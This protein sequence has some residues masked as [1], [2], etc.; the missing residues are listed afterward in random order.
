LR[1]GR[2]QSN[3]D[4]GDRWQHRYEKFDRQMNVTA[5]KGDQHS[6]DGGLDPAEAEPQCQ[7]YHFHNHQA[8]QEDLKQMSEPLGAARQN[9]GNQKVFQQALPRANRPHARLWSNSM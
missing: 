4:K 8:G 6:S 2:E 5:R 3:E 9:H 7:P 1:E